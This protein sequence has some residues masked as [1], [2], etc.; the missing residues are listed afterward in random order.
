MFDF[1]FDF[2]EDTQYNK[3]DICGLVRKMKSKKRLL[4]NLPREVWQL[5]ACCG[6]LPRN[7]EV[8]KALSVG[9][10]WS[11]LAFIKWVADTEKVEELFVSTFRI[12]KNHIIELDK[13]ANSNRLG[14]C[15]FL[16][17]ASQKKYRRKNE[18]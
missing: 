13:L 10:G 3:V 5:K 4:W 1:D 11:S 7:D 8:V 2:G 6:E 16:T 15:H 18:L 12:G 17:N 9:G 14:M